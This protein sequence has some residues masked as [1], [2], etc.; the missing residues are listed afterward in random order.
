ML[1]RR[2]T[3]TGLAFRACGQFGQRLRQALLQRRQP[4]HGLGIRF[5][6]LGE[7]DVGGG[8]HPDLLADVIEGQ[9]FV[10]EQQAGVGNTEFVLGVVGQ[11]LD[12]AHRIVGEESDRASGEGRQSGDA[13]RLVAAERVAQHVEDVALDA[14]G[15]PGLR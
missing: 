4:L 9:H 3:S 10:E 7:R 6:R 12:L 14:R 8:D 15:A 1:V 11:S 2:F 5:I 13:G